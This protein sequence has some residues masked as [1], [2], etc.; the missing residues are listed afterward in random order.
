MSDEI[1]NTASAGE[2]SEDEEIVFAGSESTA[3]DNDEEEVV[4]YDNSHIKNEPEYVPFV[5]Q[6]PF[7]GSSSDEPGSKDGTAGVSKPKASKKR[8]AFNVVSIILAVIMILSGSGC[9]VAYSWFTR[10]NYVAIDNDESYISAQSSQVS[11]QASQ[12]NAKTYEGKLL[13]DQQI[14]NILLIGADTRYNATSGNSDTMIILSIDTKHQKIKMLSLMR[15]TYVAIPG[16]DNNKLNATFSI[17]GADLTVRTIQLNYGIQ[18]DRYAIVD[19]SSFK[20]IIDTLGGLDIELT[21]DEVDYVNWQLWINDQDEYKNASGDYKE[22]VREQLKS[23]WLSSAY[24][25]EINKSKLKF[26]QKEDDDPKAKVKL[27][28]RQALWHARNRGEDGICS[29]DDYVRTTRQREV[30]ALMLGK[31]KKTDFGTMMNIIMKIGPMITTNLKTSEI[32]ALAS[33]MPK[34]LS[35]DIVSQSAPDRAALGPDYYF[36]DIDYVGNCIIIIDWE[37]FRN[38]VA[39]FVFEDENLLKVEW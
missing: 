6:T 1:R 9:V 33:N 20:D 17:E 25:R 12:K 22:S 26:K 18:I 16:H 38:K 30:I 14:L 36:D 8:V 11:L 3:E 15:D 37:D 31:L 35:Y 23:V 21:E 28:G 19:F 4:F 13:N 5:S 10:I 29:G 39:K 24:G 7:S 2:P 32:T 27:T 34:Y